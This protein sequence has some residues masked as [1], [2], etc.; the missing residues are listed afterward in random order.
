MNPP[1]VVTYYEVSSS[2]GIHFESL[3]QPEAFRF[4][5]EKYATEG[6]E[7][8]ITEVEREARR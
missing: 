7:C 8:R 4:A 1:I 3:S 6:I 5:R 2:A